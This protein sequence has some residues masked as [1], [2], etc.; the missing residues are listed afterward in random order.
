MNVRTQLPILRDRFGQP[1]HIWMSQEFDEKG[2]RP[3]QACLSRRLAHDVTILVREGK[4]RVALL[5][6]HTHPPGY[7]SQA[8][9]ALPH[10][11]DFAAG[12]EAE[13]RAE[14]G[15]QI[16]LEKFLAQVTL[17][18]RHG[19]DLTPWDTYV[20]TA[21]CHESP[22]KIV[23]TK[24]L[25][26]VA[27]TQME[28]IAEKLMASDQGGLIYRGRLTNSIRW[29]LEH[30]LHLREATPKDYPLIEVTLRRSRLEAP[31]FEKSVW[32]VAEIEGFF[33]GNVGLTPHQDC[34]ELTGL[35]VDPIF[36]GRGVGNALVEFAMSRVIL[37]DKR[38]QLSERM[39]RPLQ[40]QLWLITDLPGYF[41]PAGFVLAN[42]QDIPVSLR[43]KTGELKA[44]MRYPRPTAA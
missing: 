23:Q 35:S 26:W 1:Y 10:Q 2:W 37:P 4:E 29:A 38:R 7:I 19:D 3:V 13:V 42:N 28:M 40:D 24:E 43:P 36:R 22:T 12:V 11:A 44:P 25:M 39:G 17:D 14:T 41:M 27:P 18:I 32:W 21:S 33:A 15:L 34:L 16:K 20:F 8:A 6:R 5:S 30:E 9:Q 31:D